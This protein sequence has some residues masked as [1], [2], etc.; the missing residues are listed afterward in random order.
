MRQNVLVI[1]MKRQESP[2]CHKSDKIE[3]QK[4]FDIIQSAA[5]SLMFRVFRNLFTVIIYFFNCLRIVLEFQFIQEIY[6]KEI[7]HMLNCISLKIVY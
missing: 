7:D 5:E 3:T 4:N 1:L 6:I 2:R